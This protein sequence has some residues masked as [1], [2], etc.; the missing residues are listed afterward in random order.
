[1]TTKLTD[2]GLAKLPPGEYTDPAVKG[3]QVRIRE[4]RHGAARRTWLLRYK[5]QGQPVRISIGGHGAGLADARAA[6]LEARHLIDAGIDPRTAERP[7]RRQSVRKALEPGKLAPTHSPHSIEHLAREYIDRHVARRRKRPEYVSRFLDA[8]VLT[9]AAWA[10]RDVRTIT[11]REVIELLDGIVDRGSPAMANRGAG[12]LA[13]MFKFGVHRA[14]V[15][16]SPVQLLYRPGGKEKARERALADHEI[17]FLL[18][19]LESI[20]R[21]KTDQA[22]RSPRLAH[23]LRVLLLTGQR[24]GEL[25]NARWVN[26]TL[27]GKAPAW[28][29]PAEDSKTGAAHLVP[30]SP[31]AVAEFKALKQYAG[32]SPFVIP[33]EDGTAAADA[34]LITRSVSRNLKRLQAAAAE[35]NPP[36]T[37]EP[38]T[39]H[40]LRR[41]CR[42]G[43]ARLKVS[44][45]I[46][47]RILNHKLP[48]MREVYD[49]HEPLD[50]MRAALVKWAKHLAMLETS[51][52]K[53]AA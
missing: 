12:I 49:Q 25:A 32:S 4:D 27:T 38:F 28:Q 46:G 2:K 26:V 41:T 17:A 31:A 8:E 9:P 22:G 37:L 10:G 20:M 21:F 48:A 40:D 14:I 39:V 23:A 5:W 13:Q 24:R 33:T 29:I 45:D 6:A 35:Q 52:A 36:I 53:A 18:C 1:M 42:T 16:A 44:H 30:L 50:E 11:P 15:D 43:L 34:K 51:T 47:E 7:T 19:N 3:L